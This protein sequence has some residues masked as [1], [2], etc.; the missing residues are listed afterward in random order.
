MR[1]TLRT[2]IAYLDNVLPPE[3][4]KDIAGQLER[5]EAARELVD[6]RRSACSKLRLGAPD[7]LATGGDADANTIAEYLDNTLPSDRVAR[8]ERTCLDS[9][10][11]FAEVCST[12]QLLSQTDGG[13]DVDSNTRKRLYRMSGTDDRRAKSVELPEFPAFVIAPEGGGVTRSTANSATRRTDSNHGSTVPSAPSGNRSRASV[14]APSPERVRILRSTT[15]HETSESQAP[16]NATPVQTPQ[17]TQAPDRRL[18]TSAPLAAKP[19]RVEPP[20]ETAP[21]S[22]QTHVGDSTIRRPHFA[23]DQRS[24]K[25]SAKVSGQRLQE[26]EAGFPVWEL[27]AFVV[28]LLVGIGW[29]ADQRMRQNR[30]EVAAVSTKRAAA[31]KDEDSAHPNQAQIQDKQAAAPPKAIAIPHPQPEAPA[32]VGWPEPLNTARMDTASSVAAEANPQPTSLFSA[33]AAPRQHQPESVDMGE[34]SPDPAVSDVD[35]SKNEGLEA[36]DNVDVSKTVEIETMHAVPTENE[37]LEASPVATADQNDDAVN[38]NEVAPPAIATNVIADASVQANAANTALE[39]VDV[40]KID[41]NKVQENEF[42]PQ[43]AVAEPTDTT[44]ITVD[45]G[46]GMQPDVAASGDPYEAQSSTWPE[47]VASTVNPGTIARAPLPE[48]DAYDSVN[49]DNTPDAV[50]AMA[51]RTENSQPARSEAYPDVAEAEPLQMPTSADV[52]EVSPSRHTPI[53]PRPDDL[54]GAETSHSVNMAS[55]AQKKAWPA[56]PALT[57]KQGD[58]ILAAQDPDQNWVRSDAIAG[59]LKSIILF[60]PKR[61][62]AEFQLGEPGL[63]LRTLGWSLCKLTWNEQQHLPVLKV[64]FGNVV[65]ANEQLDNAQLAIDW[66]GTQMAATMN[67]GDELGIVAVPNTESDDSIAN[68]PSVFFNIYGLKGAAQLA[69]AS[70]L[71]TA[72]ITISQG[73]MLGSASMAVAQASAS[74]PADFE[75]RPRLALDSQWLQRWQK[76]LAEQPTI[77]QGLLQLAVSERTESAKGS[78]DD[79]PSSAAAALTWM[80]EPLAA[81][82]ALNDVRMSR[83]WPELI[84]HLRANAVAS[85]GGEGRLKDA[86][87]IVY[88]PEMGEQLFEFCWGVDPATVEAD[89]DDLLVA[90]LDHPVLACRVLCLWNLQRLTGA[91]HGYRPEADASARSRGLKN[92]QSALRKQRIRLSDRT[93]DGSIKGL[94]R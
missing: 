53:A 67:P 90:G 74:I 85:E 57:Q 3:Q 47:H 83:A 84:Q 89:V 52:K 86:F 29:M 75:Q 68:P 34:H 12:H 25:P 43:H 36:I 77:E 11:L 72:P 15:S 65:I 26:T 9:E 51:A 81:V 2:L 59:P 5:S 35:V 82:R 38:M 4:A 60:A 22:Q 10:E 18:P 56:P 50:A 13:A 32:S 14:N 16:V 45:S 49:I 93:V 91:T 66:G 19:A 70:D 69:N 64:I 33:D 42:D 73:Q 63:K 88:G 44:D 78:A 48:G 61:H 80:G 1:L 76:A 37:A 41:N 20:R 27:A 92:W 55:D 31:T 94:I 8:F 71:A 87:R 30:A 28:I 54:E 6:R 58:L 40:A 24:A 23:D 17:T 62:Q 79:L 21:T 7:P 39:A 46:P